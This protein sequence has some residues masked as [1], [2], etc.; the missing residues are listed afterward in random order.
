LL[1]RASGDLISIDFDSDELLEEFLTLNP[2]FRET[3]ISKSGARGGNVWLRIEGEYPRTSHVLRI[4]GKGV[5]EWRANS[6]QTVIY[7]QHPSGS[8]YSDNGKRPIKIEFSAIRWP[9]RITL[10]WEK[11]ASAESN[12]GEA[13]S[14][15]G[16]FEGAGS[17]ARRR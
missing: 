9:E 16:V 6:N 1:G 4:D 7:G 12:G 8:H 2:A 3:L 15:G 13:G 5:G 14:V 10:P 17:A 11:K